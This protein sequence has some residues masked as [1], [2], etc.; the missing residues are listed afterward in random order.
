[1]THHDSNPDSNPMP[2][3]LCLFAG[4][5]L[6]STQ[7][8]QP[9]PDL[10]VVAARAPAP[11]LAPS[12]DPDRMPPRDLRRLPGIGERRALAI[13]RARWERGLRGGPEAWDSIPG[14]GPE[15]IR[16]I[17]EFLAEA[18]EVP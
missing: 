8:R 4:W 7:L 13:A 14:I 2:A 12:L 3:W 11:L 17:R 15:T 16:R 1:M 18:R 10:H 9:G 6:A 5:L